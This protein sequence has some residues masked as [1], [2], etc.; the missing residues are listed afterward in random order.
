MARW[1]C[2]LSPSAISRAHAL[3]IAAALQKNYEYDRVA[4]VAPLDGNKTLT[5]D[6]LPQAK[7][8]LAK[9]GGSCEHFPFRGKKGIL[10]IGEDG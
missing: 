2:T 3:A 6:T 8:H 1:A 4:A 9:G 10:Y 7:N 5:A